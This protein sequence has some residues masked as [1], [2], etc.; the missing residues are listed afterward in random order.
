VKLLRMSSRL[1][2]LEGRVVLVTG[3]SRRIAIGAAIARRLVADDAKVM[4]HSWSPHDAE[5]PWGGGS[6][7]ARGAAGRAAGSR[8]TSRSFRR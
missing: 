7:R 5:Q 1:R 6:R 4:I 8:R 2:A 3:A